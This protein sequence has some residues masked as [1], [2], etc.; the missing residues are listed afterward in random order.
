[1]LCYVE[2]NFKKTVRNTKHA[3]R[4]S[5]DGLIFEKKFARELRIYLLYNNKQKDVQ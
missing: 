1:M 4:N 5:F 2:T 3:L